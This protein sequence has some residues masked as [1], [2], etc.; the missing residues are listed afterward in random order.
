MIVTRIIK[1]ETKHYT[2]AKKK[3]KNLR[4]S[5]SKKAYN[6]NLNLKLTMNLKWIRQYI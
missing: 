2:S 3:K 1:E 4:I 6:A 5:D